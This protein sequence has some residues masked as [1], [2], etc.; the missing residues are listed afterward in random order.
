MKPLFTIIFLISNFIYSQTNETKPNFKI[1]SDTINFSSFSEPSFI[2]KDRKRFFMI[3]SQNKYPYSSL[4]GKFLKVFELDKLKYEKQIPDSLN[5]GYIDFFVK[6]D[7]ILYK[8]Y[9]DHKTYFLNDNFEWNRIKSTDDLIY[10]DKNFYITSLDFGE[11]GAK[12]WFKDKKKKEYQLNIFTAIINKIN[13]QYFLTTSKNIYVIDNPKKLKI[14]ESTERYE[15]YKNTNKNSNSYPDTY[16]PK[17]IFSI[18]KKGFYIVT[19]FVVNNNLYHICREPNSTY[20]GKIVG[21]KME[22]IQK[23]S[24]DIIPFTKY[25]NYRNRIID[26]KQIVQFNTNDTNFSGIMEIEGNSIHLYYFKNNFKAEN[27]GYSKAKIEFEKKLDFLIAN[28]GKINLTDIE[29]MEKNTIPINHNM[30]LLYNGKI[31]QDFLGPKIYKTTEDNYSELHTLYNYN[32]ENIVEAITFKWNR[33]ID[34][35]NQVK[36]QD[37]NSRKKGENERYDNIKKYL[38]S[39]FGQL[40]YSSEMEE[41]KKN[42]WKVEQKTIELNQ[43]KYFLEMKIFIN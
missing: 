24:S 19:S 17:P 42:K 14:V 4:E 28:I 26:N 31:N 6:N 2:L 33:N 21:N 30:R 35:E 36:F 27:L 22:V 38:I 39:K 5:T 7:S 18:D 20:I 1:N 13:S 25:F 37:D 3:C 34:Y 9:L 16:T 10:Q 43:G 15:N 32:K 23:L 8:K 40:E 12:T 11:F 29:N 41:N